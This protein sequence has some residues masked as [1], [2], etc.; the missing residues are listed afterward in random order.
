MFSGGQLKAP[1]TLPAVSTLNHGSTGGR[2]GFFHTCIPTL[3][4]SAALHEEPLPSQAQNDPAWAQQRY[5]KGCSLTQS[6]QGV[7]ARWEMEHRTARQGD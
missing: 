6:S 4:T 3:W 5:R 7:S 2:Q 1:E